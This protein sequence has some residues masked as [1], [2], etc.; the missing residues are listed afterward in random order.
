MKIENRIN[1]AIIFSDSI[2]IL[3]GILNK[4][5]HNS[6]SRKIHN[7]IHLLKISAQ[8]IILCWVSSHAGIQGNEL[9]DTYAKEAI[10]SYGFI[11][12]QIHTYTFQ[13]LKTTFDNHILTQWQILWSTL[14]TKHNKIK[15]VVSS[16]PPFSITKMP[17]SN[18]KQTTDRSHMG[19]S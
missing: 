10:S 17:G 6:I 2:S 13:D 7:H 19:D 14:H 3:T 5:Q 8:T 12:Y 16:W 1:K 18:S 11:S 4:H 15:P 9:A